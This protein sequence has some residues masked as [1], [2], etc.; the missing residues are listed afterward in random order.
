VV[1]HLE[2]TSIRQVGPEKWSNWMMFYLNIRD[3]LVL[4]EKLLKK[5]SFQTI[6]AEKQ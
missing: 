2:R 1:Y 5:L 3:M 4:A 6:S